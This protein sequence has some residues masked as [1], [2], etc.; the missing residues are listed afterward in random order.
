M[1][2][3]KKIKYILTFKEGAS[4]IFE[5][6]LRSSTESKERII[7]NLHQEFGTKKFI[8]FFNDGMVYDLFLKDSI[9][10]ATVEDR[11]Y[12]RARIANI[13]RKMEKSHGKPR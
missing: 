10:R 6:E 4:L 5:G 8:V 13:I 2:S 11:N 1:G 7:N 9:G 3:T 12:S